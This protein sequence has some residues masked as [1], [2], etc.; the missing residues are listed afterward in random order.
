MERLPTLSPD[1]L[2]EACDQLLTSIQRIERT[3]FDIR[4]DDEDGQRHLIL[5][6]LLHIQGSRARDM[7]YIEAD[8]P[9]ETLD[10]AVEDEEINEVDEVWSN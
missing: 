5:K 10:Q 4:I 8:E 3:G 1:D 9:G 2:N 7:E 6:R